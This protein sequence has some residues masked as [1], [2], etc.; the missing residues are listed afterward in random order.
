MWCAER[1]LLAGRSEILRRFA[2]QNDIY[3]NP[4][5]EVLGASLHVHDLAAQG[6]GK[7][8]RVGHLGP[9]AIGHI[10]YVQHLIDI[11][12]DL[13]EVND[14]AKLKERIRD[15]EEQSHAIGSSDVDHGV[16]CGAA[17]IYRHLGRDMRM[18]LTEERWWA[19]GT[20]QVFHPALPAQ[21]CT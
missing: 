17:V 11:R 10:E 14:E 8:V 12:G 13:G 18:T 1:T 4:V 2:P 6:T 5:V 9:A 3:Q 20:Q 16:A 19:C 21:H 7:A 15:G